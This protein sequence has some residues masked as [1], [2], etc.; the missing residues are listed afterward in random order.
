LARDDERAALPE[1]D[2]PSKKFA[3]SIDA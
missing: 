3:V 2:G 1:E